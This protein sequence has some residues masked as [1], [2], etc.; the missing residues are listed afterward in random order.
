M[1]SSERNVKFL[2]EEVPALLAHLK[3]DSKPLWG[4]MT[5]Q[6]MLEHLKYSLQLTTGAK[7]VKVIAPW[8]LRPIYKF[9]ILSNLF[10]YPKNIRL[11]RKLLA[12][13]P[14]LKYASMEE[15]KAHLIWAIEETIYFMRKS[16]EVRTSHPLAGEFTPS[17][18]KRFHY[19]HFQHHFKQFGL[20]PSTY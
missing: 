19:K 4:I 6:H 12:S 8:Y 14:P 7:T 16:P 10:N 17:N 15:A 18:W 2:T 11:N 1:S 3:P 20:L 13:L 5:P 9:L